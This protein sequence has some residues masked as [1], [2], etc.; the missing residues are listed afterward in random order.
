MNWK[1][2]ISFILFFSILFSVF[3]EPTIKIDSLKN[4]LKT[5]PQKERLLLLTNI[6]NYYLNISP[7]SCFKYASNALLIAK[8]QANDTIIADMYT[9]MGVSTHYK[10]NDARAFE[11][12]TYAIQKYKLIGNKE[13]LSS[14]YVNMGVIYYSN[15][16]YQKAIKYYKLAIEPFKA[17]EEKKYLTVLYDNIGLCYQNI[18]S[19][20]SAIEYYE[21]SIE[22]KNKL[23]STDIYNALSS[24][25]LVYRL[26]KEY[27]KAL[28]NYQKILDYTISN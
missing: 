10:G 22:I 24:I 9:A 28:D 17:L 18:D 1:Q 3:A 7:D 12:F 2:N 21:K 5:A 26:K 20:N 25:S 13:K 16:D 11:Y 19:V 4:Q 8:K 23:D 15:K 14:S 6:A 27:K